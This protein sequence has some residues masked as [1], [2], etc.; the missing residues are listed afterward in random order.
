MVLY[1]VEQKKFN[2]FLNNNITFN[3]FTLKEDLLKN[4]KN[5]LKA[6]FSINEMQTEINNDIII[7]IA[8]NNLLEQIVKNKENNGFNDNWDLI[9]NE[10]TLICIKYFDFLK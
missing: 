2:E 10:K 4:I 9:N 6:I 3:N 7:N 8:L 5:E 1:E